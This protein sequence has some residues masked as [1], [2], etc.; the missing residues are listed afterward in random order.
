MS[1]RLYLDPYSTAQNSDAYHAPLDDEFENWFH[2]DEVN[3]IRAGKSHIASAHPTSNHLKTTTGAQAQAKNQTDASN[4]EEILPYET[5]LDLYTQVS[6]KIWPQSN[7][8][9]RQ[10]VLPLR[11][12]APQPLEAI[13][14][15]RL[16]QRPVIWYPERT[17]HMDH[18]QAS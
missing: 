12:Q 16:T 17:G 10:V 1:T 4:P 14:I 13:D 3:R 5:Y 8:R 11:I 9:S 2:L 6:S 7:P 18:V 15:N